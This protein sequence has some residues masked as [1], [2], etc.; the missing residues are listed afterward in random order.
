MTKEDQVRE[1]RTARIVR[2]G[3]DFIETHFKPDAELTPEGIRENIRARREIC[4]G[5]PH[6][7]LSIFPGEHDLDPSVMRTDLYAG[8]D[9]MEAVQALAL[10]ITDDLLPSVAQLYFTYFPQTFR[11]AVF[12]DEATARIWLARELEVLAER[13]D[14]P[15]EG[16]RD[17]D[18]QE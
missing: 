18:T 10:V 3:P 15:T 16:R 13:Q 9:G 12:R 7:V 17:R 6:V 5:T 4:Q 14:R 1:T 2:V 8:S 11:T